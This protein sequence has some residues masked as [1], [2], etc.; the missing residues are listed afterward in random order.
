MHCLRSADRRVS[1]LDL[2][3]RF[4]PPLPVS[5][6]VT[7]EALD[8]APR[9]SEPTPDPESPAIHSATRWTES[10]DPCG[11]GRAWPD[12]SDARPVLHLHHRGPMAEQKRTWY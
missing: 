7:A 10:S 8:S 3:S 1:P 2:C 11:C 5:C 6:L 12:L 9:R 4:L